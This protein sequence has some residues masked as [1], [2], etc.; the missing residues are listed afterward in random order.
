MD[1]ANCTGWH[2]TPNND[3]SI[4]SFYFYE[5]EQFVI[6]W[7][8][9]I[10]IVLGNSAV[11]CALKFGVKR[12]S[13]M[14]FFIMHLAVADLCVGVLSVLTDIVWRSSVTWKAGNTACKVVRYSQA[15]VT[16]SS[17]YVLVAL[18]I[19]RYYAI[20]YPMNFCG[21][22]RRARWLVGIAWF[23]SFILSIPIA[24]LFHVR[25]IQ[26]SPQCWIEFAEPWQW[27]LYM[28]LVALA[29]FVIPALI[30]SICYILIIATIWAKS[31]LYSVSAVPGQCE[32]T[33]RASSRG[34]IPKAKVK[35]VKMTFI[36]L[37]ES[38]FLWITLLESL[39][40]IRVSTDPPKVLLLIMLL[41][42][43]CH[44]CV[45]SRIL[46]SCQFNSSSAIKINSNSDQL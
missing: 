42:I 21:S 25:P 22:W 4:N 9:F 23:T 11:I 39:F 6:L 43:L 13:R 15:V 30:I 5:T 41:D 44:L 28:S 1:S 36:I 3:T 31:K 37:L 26:G 14:N 16:Y 46:F 19:D 8:L 38:L 27:Q 12:R 24:I 10:L 40:P 29:L 45:K 17:T 32:D 35:S 34:I 2:C 33:R 18:S 7:F 20:K